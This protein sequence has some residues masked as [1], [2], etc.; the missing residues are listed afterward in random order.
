MYD[1]LVS[2]K[3]AKGNA[4]VNQPLKAILAI[5]IYISRRA[6]DQPLKLKGMLESAHTNFS[7]PTTSHMRIDGLNLALRQQIVG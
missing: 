2:Y 7:G 6:A 5:Y 1:R 3:C 4:I